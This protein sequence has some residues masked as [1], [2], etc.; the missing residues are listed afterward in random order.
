MLD[1]LDE[2]LCANSFDSGEVYQI[3]NPIHLG[4]DYTVPCSMLGRA[5]KEKWLFLEKCGRTDET[6]GKNYRTVK[7]QRTRGFR[8]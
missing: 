5:Q 1:A 3:K 6:T 7:C 8:A 2:L 4:D